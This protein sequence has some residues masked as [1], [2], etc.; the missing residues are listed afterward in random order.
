MGGVAAEAPVQIPSPEKPQAGQLRLAL[1]HELTRP[2]FTPGGALDPGTRRL[3]ACLRGRLGK[4][5]QAQARVLGD[6]PPCAG[7]ETRGAAALC[8]LCGAAGAATGTAGA[9]A[10]LQHDP[11]ERRPGEPRALTCTLWRAFSLS[12]T[13]SSPERPRWPFRHPAGPE[14]CPLSSPSPGTG[15]QLLSSFPG[16]AHLG[17]LL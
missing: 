4:E 14:G 9:P 6:R 7:Q 2:G 16:G 15:V 11:P 8:P 5:A 1:T 13:P 17:C 12:T 10:S 3:Q